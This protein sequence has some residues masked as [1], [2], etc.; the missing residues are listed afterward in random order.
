MKIAISSPSQAPVFQSNR[1]LSTFAGKMDIRS[2]LACYPPLQTDDE[3]M[4]F[5]CRTSCLG[6]WSSV[7]CLLL[8]NQKV[9]PKTE[10]SR[11][12]GAMAICRTHVMV[13]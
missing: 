3:K 13:C 1:I 5:A 8:D 7:I 10:L 11:D 9:P 12:H 2:F 4:S 6:I